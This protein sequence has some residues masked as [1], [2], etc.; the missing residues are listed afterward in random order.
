M[1]KFKAKLYCYDHEP[2]NL[3]PEYDDE[4]HIDI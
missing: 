1:R 2:D 4:I 3:E